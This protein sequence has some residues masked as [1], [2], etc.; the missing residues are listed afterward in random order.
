[1]VLG[2]ESSGDNGKEEEALNDEPTKN[3]FEVL[4]EQGGSE[5]CR[6]RK[7]EEKKTR[8]QAKAV[9]KKEKVEKTGKKLAEVTARSTKGSVPRAVDIPKKT[10]VTTRQHMGVTIEEI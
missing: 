5:E 2:G 7:K 3:R 6:Q 1:M 8:K 9:A 10:K 4:E